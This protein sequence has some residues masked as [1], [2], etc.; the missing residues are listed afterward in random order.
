MIS[1]LTVP[2]HWSETHP[3]H[4][5]DPPVGRKTTDKQT[6]FASFGSVAG[7]FRSCA[8]SYDGSPARTEWRRASEY[9]RADRRTP[10]PRQVRA[11]VV[12]PTAPGKL[13]IESVELRDPDRDEVTVR[14]TA[15]SL[16]RGETRR[17][18]QQAEPG[19]RPGW[20]FVGVIE[21]AAAGP[22]PAR[23]WSASCHRAPGPNGSIAE[24][25]RSPRCRMQSGIPRRRHY[26][27]RASPRCTRCARAGCCSDARCWSAAPWV[28]SGISP[29]SSLRQLVRKSEAMCAGRYT[30][31]P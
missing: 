7:G 19:W 5:L 15:I 23:A 14:V 30:A 12:D 22:D 9:V 11:V 4:P 16:N 20:D 29:A 8:T 17:A 3:L 27:L 1:S 2:T 26:R 25:M 24:R 31:P 13:A 21:T 28:G 18:V 6:A 10:M